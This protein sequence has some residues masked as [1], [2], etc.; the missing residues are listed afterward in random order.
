MTSDINVPFQAISALC[1]VL[2][3]ELAT[4]ISASARRGSVESSVKHVS[5]P[6]N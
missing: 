2:M 4:K 5:S 6:L 3:E 1:Y